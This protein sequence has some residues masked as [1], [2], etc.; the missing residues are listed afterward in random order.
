MESRSVNHLSVTKDIFL[1]ESRSVNHLSV[2]KDIFDG[3]QES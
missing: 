1:M 2:T 3:K